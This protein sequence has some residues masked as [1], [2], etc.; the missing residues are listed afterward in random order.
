MSLRDSPQC[1]SGRSGSAVGQLAIGKDLD[2]PHRRRERTPHSGT[3][4]T[5]RRPPRH[6]ASGFSAAGPSHNREARPGEQAWDRPDAVAVEVAN[7]LRKFI[8]GHEVRRKFG[9][10]IATGSEAPAL[11]ETVFNPTDVLYTRKHL[12]LVWFEFHRLASTLLA[13]HRF[14][15]DGREFAFDVDCLV[16]ARRSERFGQFLPA[17]KG[18]IVVR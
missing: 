15:A 1:S 10:A 16:P 18:G 13:E 17:A 5:R 8:P 11:P 14:A 9:R 7:F 3:W 4:S 6:R 12:D 2:L